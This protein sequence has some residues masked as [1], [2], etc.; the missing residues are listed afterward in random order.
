MDAELAPFL[1]GEF[2]IFDMR[3]VQPKA[4]IDVAADG[5]VDWAMRPSAPFDR[6]PDLDRE[7]DGHRRPDHDPPCGERTRRISFRRSTPRSRRNRSTGPW[8]V[9]GSLR[10][11][12]MRTAVS[13]STGK[14]DEKR[15][16]AAQGAGRAGDLSRLDRSRRRCP[17]RQAAR[18]TMPG[19][20]KIA[21]RAGRAGGG[22]N[23]A[24][25]AEAGRATASTAS[26]RS[27]TSGSSFD[28]F[29]FETGPL[30]NPYSADGKGFVDLGQEP[31]FALSMDGAQV[32]FDEAIGADG[33]G[34][35][36]T[37]AERL[38]ALQAALLDLPKPAI[39][40]TIEVDLPAVVAGDTTIRDVQPVGRAGGRRLDPEVARRDAARTHDARSRRPSQDRKAIRLRRLAAARDRPA[41]RF[42]GLGVEGCRRRDP[43]AAGRRI[44]GQGRPDQRAPELQ[45][46]RTG[47]RQ[48]D[49]PRRGRKPAA[50]RRQAV[51]RVLKLAGGALDVD[52]L[53]AFASLFVSDQ[54]ASRFADRD[55]DLQVKA[56]PVSAGGLTAETV[57]TA[58]QAARGRC[59]RS[60][61]C[62]SA[63]WPARRSARPARSRISRPIRPAMSTPR[64]WRSTSRR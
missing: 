64:S 42:R 36:L 40:G 16:D 21:A 26:S 59:S 30:D 12:G 61:G 9:D 39:P 18:R 43:A 47:A 29:R 58:L 22:R 50:A 8:R 5:T 13:V 62:R 27:T 4:T 32:R 1:R 3:L 10:L 38:A 34:G 11:D 23:S 55:L 15:R 31:R 7:A 56:G 44:P 24:A 51:D 25:E 37:L 41:V 2:L 17:F 48:C 54:G 28:E 19:T 52:G 45:R 49:I 35:G 57:D 14:V 20:F 6:E 53:A 46:S 60:T 33:E 63:G